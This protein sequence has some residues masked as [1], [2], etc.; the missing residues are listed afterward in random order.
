MRTRIYEAKKERITMKHTYKALITILVLSLMTSML[1]G[2]KT[3]ATGIFNDE[4]KT[5]ATGTFND[6]KP[7][8]RDGFLK[9]MLAHGFEDFSEYGN[10]GGVFTF[11]SSIKESDVKDAVEV[12]RE[13]DDTDNHQDYVWGEFYDEALA[14]TYFV[15]MAKDL[16]AVYSR[17]T[18]TVLI[19][20][21]DSHDIFW[22]ECQYIG[23]VYTS[24][25]LAR[26][27]STIVYCNGARYEKGSETDDIEE[28][29][30]E[31][32]YYWPEK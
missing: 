5:A 15:E 30:K 17:S 2:C 3:A 25:C 19:D 22:V 6:E 11:A 24:Y 21:N 9:V 13:G 7:V 23:N 32:G 16:K 14:K 20:L 29:F 1:T 31:L 28:I 8:D 4:N 26:I 12:Y 18:D 27:G 10:Y